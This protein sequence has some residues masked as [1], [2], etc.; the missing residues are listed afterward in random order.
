ME[1][2]V[3]GRGPGARA[4][5]EGCHLLCSSPLGRAACCHVGATHILYDVS[6][7]QGCS[8]SFLWV[9]P[10]PIPAPPTLPNT[11]GSMSMSMPRK[12]LN[13]SLSINTHP[14]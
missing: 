7:V 9:M 5:G 3:R 12:E 10:C 8:R 2:A 1:R 13:P 14:C 4:R 11:T 6:V